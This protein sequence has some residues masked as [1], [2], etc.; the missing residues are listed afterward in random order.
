MFSVFTWQISHLLTWNRTLRTL[1]LISS[2]YGSMN[3]V[4]GGFLQFQEP[5]VVPI[6]L[7]GIGDFFVPLSSDNFDLLPQSKVVPPA[8]KPSV[9]QVY[10][11]RRGWKTPAPGR[12][13]QSKSGHFWVTEAQR[14]RPVSPSYLVWR[15]HRLGPVQSSLQDVDKQVKVSPSLLRLAP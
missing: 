15:G 1:T 5:K 6:T 3:H 9:T 8:Q 10:V 12:F 13:Y 4:Y 11:G 14:Q 7:Y 2:K